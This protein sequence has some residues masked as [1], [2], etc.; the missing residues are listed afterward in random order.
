ML[1]VDPQAL[2]ILTKAFF[3]QASPAE[4][5]PSTETRIYP[6][7]LTGQLN[8]RQ[9]LVV[10]G[11]WQAQTV[12]SASMLSRRVGIRYLRGAALWGLCPE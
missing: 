7:C 6:E 2:S 12:T 11:E 9:I 3:G 10:K 8:L 4:R 5:S 1:M